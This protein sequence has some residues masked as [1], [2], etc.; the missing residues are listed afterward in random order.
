M[1]VTT[2]LSWW[3]P[4][5]SSLVNSGTSIV[6]CVDHLIHH[7]ILHYKSLSK[8]K[9]N[10]T[11]T[12]TESVLYIFRKSPSTFINV[13]IYLC[14]NTFIQSSYYGEILRISVGRALVVATEP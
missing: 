6:S 1:H 7:V 13:G 14:P 9:L 3:G 12:E 8:L 11:S 10:A 2:M 4:L 5:F